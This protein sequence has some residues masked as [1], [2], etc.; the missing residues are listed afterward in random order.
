MFKNKLCYFL[1]LFLLLILSSCGEYTPMEQRLKDENKQLETQIKELKEENEKLSNEITKKDVTIDELQYSLDETEILSILEDEYIQSYTGQ[2]NGYNISFDIEQNARV[3][4]GD[5]GIMILKNDKSLA[6]ISIE[7][8]NKL[9]AFRYVQNEIDYLK[10]NVGSENLTVK[11]RNELT[12]NNSTG[13]EAVLQTPDGIYKYVAVRI[14]DDYLIIY[15]DNEGGSL[16]QEQIELA[17][18]ICS[19]IK[20][21]AS[22]SAKTQSENKIITSPQITQA[23][24][25]NISDAVKTSAPIKNERIVYRGKTGTKY[26]KK[27]CPTLKGKGRPISL[28]EAKK[29]GRQACQVC[30]G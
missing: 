23:P 22:P 29:Q 19:T 1:L 21:S 15:L 28:E 13:Y 27:T 24:K 11:S 2:L 16:M 20:V 18:T 26:H 4:E 14:R 17:A 8:A 9:T 10:N 12:I 6:A 7:Y 3:Y 25:I 30:G 5:G